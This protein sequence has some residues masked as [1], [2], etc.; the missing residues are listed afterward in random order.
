MKKLKRFVEEGWLAIRV[1]VSW[2]LSAVL[3]MCV[4]MLVHHLPDVPRGGE[5]L[6]KTVMKA[7]ELSHRV[8]A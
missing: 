5:R 1:V 3:M 7:R 6:L 2:L 4:G 8:V